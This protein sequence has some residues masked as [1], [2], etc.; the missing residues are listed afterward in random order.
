MRVA[1]GLNSATKKKNWRVRDPADAIGDYTFRVAGATLDRWILAP[2]LRAETPRLASKYSQRWEY[3]F[4][5]RLLGAF[6][7]K[8]ITGSGPTV[9]TIDFG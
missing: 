9:K 4:L 3:H 6:V 5:I 2:S 1:V 8:N 7:R